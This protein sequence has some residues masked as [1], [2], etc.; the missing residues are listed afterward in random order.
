MSNY[1]RPGTESRHNL[2]YWRY[3]DYAGIG[4]GAHGRISWSTDNGP[5]AIH[6]TRRHRAPEPWAERV[7]RQGHGL[8][9]EVRLVAPEPAREMLLMGLRLA[10][11]IDAGRFAARTG[12]GLLDAL[13]P[14]ILEAAVEAGYLRW[15]GSRLAATPDGRLR[16]EA[17]L[18]ALVR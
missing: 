5:P 16:L 6:A 8:T 7:E 11:G 13:E 14:D 10:E 17:L 9:E 12:T 15:E 1:A 2:A 18:R 4:P 3:G